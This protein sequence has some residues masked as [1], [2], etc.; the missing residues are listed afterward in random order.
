MSEQVQATEAPTT[1]P[2]V[3]TQATEQSTEQKVEAAKELGQEFDD[4]KVTHFCIPDP[5]EIET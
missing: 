3:E 2:V 4:Y 1:E 5:I